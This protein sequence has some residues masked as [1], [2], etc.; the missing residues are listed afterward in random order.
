MIHGNTDHLDRIYDVCD[1]LGINYYYSQRPG[2]I[3]LLAGPSRRG[4]HFTMMGWRIDPATKTRMLKPSA[5][6]FAERIQKHP[7]VQSVTKIR[8]Q[9]N[10]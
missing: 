9:Q 3:S 10:F 1:I 5:S 8:P 4:K 7:T 6:W 2:P